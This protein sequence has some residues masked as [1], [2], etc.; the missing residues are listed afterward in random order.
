MLRSL[1]NA[2]GRVVIASPLPRSRGEH[3]STGRA[4]A[5]AQHRPE[6]AE[7]PASPRDQAT[8]EADPDVARLV[9]ELRRGEPAARNQLVRQYL[10][11]V[12]RIVAGALGPDGELDDVVH[13]VFVRAL[14]GVGALKDPGALVGWLSTL[15]VFTARE[16]IRRRRRWRW[17]RFLAPEALPET[18]ARAADPD[19]RATLRAAYR[20][21]EAL[22]A[23]EQ[24][25][26]GLRFIAEMELTEVAAACGCSLAT[27]KRRLAR[28]EASFV[29][30]A[31]VT[32]ALAERLERGGRGG[33]LKGETP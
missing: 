30:V 28:A 5:S 23:D 33:K 16:K 20:A 14:E 6:T 12:E 27:I 21:L 13:D 26:F 32:P 24:V 10:P 17:I 3:L 11:R 1:E 7:R 15:A 29:A 9:E 22:P 8:R 25:A 4:S 2:V 19:A 31:R 18:P